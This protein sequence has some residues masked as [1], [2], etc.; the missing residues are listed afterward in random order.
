MTNPRTP[1]EALRKLWWQVCEQHNARKL[2]TDERWAGECTGVTLNSWAW[3]ALLDLGVM[4]EAD[5]LDA[6]P[7]DMS[8]D[9]LETD[10]RT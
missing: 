8:M 7:V 6:I 2:R 1:A 10:G 5:R 4:A 9:E 3:N